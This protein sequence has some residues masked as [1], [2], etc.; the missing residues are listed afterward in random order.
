MLVNPSSETGLGMNKIFWLSFWQQDQNNFAHPPLALSPQDRD[1]HN[2]F[3][4]A[5]DYSI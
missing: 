3:G 4:P 1:A 2:F 5:Q